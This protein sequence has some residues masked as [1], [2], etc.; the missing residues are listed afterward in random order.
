M[1]MKNWYRRQTDTK[2]NR[3]TQIHTNTHE[4]KFLVIEMTVS[5]GRLNFNG[6]NGPETL[7]RVC[8]TSRPQVEVVLSIW[9]HGP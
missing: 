9:S 8:T 5:L 4:N 2:L 3:T 6:C 7:S 1:Y